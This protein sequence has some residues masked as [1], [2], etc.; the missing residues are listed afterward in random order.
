MSRIVE[1][2]EE[3]AL[4][5]PAAV[6]GN[7]PPRTR[8]LVDVR[9]NAIVLKPVDGPPPFWASASPQERAADLQRWTAS[10]TDEPG[11]PDEALR[12]ERM[13]D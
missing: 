8:Y 5:L 3:G 2:N 1:V 10:H 9:G 6:L 7:A 4:N 13:Y 12:R 11:L